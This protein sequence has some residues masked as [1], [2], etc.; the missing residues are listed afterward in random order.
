MNISTVDTVY[1]K[2]LLSKFFTNGWGD[3]QS[4]KRIFAFRK[5]ISNRETCKRLVD[6]NHPIYLDKLVESNTAY[7]V[8]EGHFSSPF[9]S[10]LPDLL[11]EEAK[12]AK[13]Q[14]VAPKVW[15][16][17]TL[18]PVCIHFA[19]TGD[20]YFWM[21]RT[22][23][24]K[25]LVKD[26]I[27]SIILENPFYGYRKPA[28]Q[29]R[30]SLKNVSDIFVM[31][32]SLIL[33]ALALL[34]YCDKLNYGP[35]CVTGISMGGHMASLAGTNWH[36]P[37]SIVPCLSWTTASCVFTQG[38]LS[39]SISWDVLQNHYN[40]FSPELCEEIKLMLNSPENNHFFDAGRRFVK[41]FPLNSNNVLEDEYISKAK[42]RVKK[43]ALNFMRGIMDECT[44]LG[45]FS[46]PVDPELAII[47]TAMNDGYVPRE[48]LIPL[49]TI[50]KGSSQRIL[51]TGH[52]AAIL[53]NMHFFREAIKD[54]LN[55]NAMKY[56]KTKLF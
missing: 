15:K 50:W 1:R 13:F 31:G 34:H 28:G 8:F 42:F 51:Q 17:K 48:G 22:L 25:P 11:P 35:L 10:Y 21:R 56:Y 47:V 54:A 45:N 55:L 29:I 53:F 39:N 3:P 23:M 16:H 43:D 41:N 46:V 19:G 24:A 30:S 38:V 7:D 37:V 5:T 9:A 33:E 18:R 44:H 27:A 32:G 6:R 26:G 14:F 4:M 20:H 2:V 40:S 49:T 36:K 52:I 12:V